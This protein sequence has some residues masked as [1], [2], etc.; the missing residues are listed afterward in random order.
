MFVAQF[1]P[2]Q[3]IDVHIPGVRQIGGF[4]ITSTPRDTG[5]KDGYIELAVQ[6]SARNPPAAWF[7]RPID[8]TRQNKIHIRAGGSFVWPPLGID[9]K[10]ITKVIFVAGGVGIKCVS[11]LIP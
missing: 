9:P 4:S 8:E 3:W 5:G 7:W 11:M 10:S 1:L 6:E 2:G